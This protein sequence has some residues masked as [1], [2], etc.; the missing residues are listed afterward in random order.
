MNRA[1][2]DWFQSKQGEPYDS[3]YVFARDAWL[4]A[5]AG[6]RPIETAP[7]GARGYTWM[8]LAW[9]SDDDKNTGAGMRCGDKFF[10]AGTFHCLGREKRF[11]F[12]EIEV[13]PTHWMPMP[14]WHEE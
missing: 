10:A 4:A 13:K 9:G 8:M 3:M 7:T 14:E 1:F 12:R 6:W 2:D 5:S 11:E